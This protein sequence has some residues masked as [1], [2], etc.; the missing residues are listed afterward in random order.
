VDRKT[1]KDLKSDKFAQEL[2]HGV[3]FMS[4]HRDDVKRYG[5]IAAAVVI[6][7]AA[8]FFYMRHQTDVREKA[9]AEAMKIDTA[10]IGA[11]PPGFLTYPTQE[12]K[13]KARTKA[14]TE[15]ASKYHG[16]QEGAMGEFYLASDAVDRGNMAE[17]EKRFKDLVDSAPSAYS[18]LA[19]LSLAKVYSGEGKDADAE[20]LLRDLMAHPTVTVSKEEATI[21]LAL[22][23]GKKNPDE[24]RKM[25]EPMRTERT[26]ISRAAVQA[27]GEVA[28]AH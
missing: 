28:G 21:Q 23:L 20:K 26:A 15:L 12:E 25:L 13:D 3:E 7:A 24:A 6:I 14:F 19:K 10:H 4:E 16:S 8:V 17:A 9:L 11:A 27:L 2:K 22:V 5:V 18:S 1:R